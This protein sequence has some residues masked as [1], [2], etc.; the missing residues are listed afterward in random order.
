VTE[1]SG[2]N[3][4]REGLGLVVSEMLWKRTPIVG[5]R[6]GGIPTQLE[7][8]VSGRLAT[9]VDEFASAVSELLEH[10]T[11]AQELGSTGHRRVREQFLIPRLLHDQLA[12]LTDVLG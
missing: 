2:Q 3:A 8:R 10:P 11:T 6:A 4:S 1:G 9:G 5:G 12:L 7:E